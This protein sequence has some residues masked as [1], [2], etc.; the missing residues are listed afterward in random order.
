MKSFFYAVISIAVAVF[1]IKKV[2]KS[3]NCTP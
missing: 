3:S 1:F 2:L